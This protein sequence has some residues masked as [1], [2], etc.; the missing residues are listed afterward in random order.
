MTFQDTQYLAE[1]VF[2][3]DDYIVFQSTGYEIPLDRCQSPS[4]I[5]AWTHHLTEKARITSEH[6][7]R[8]IQLAGMRIGLSLH[9]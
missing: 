6:L 4:E 1:E 7:R 8:F 9:G 3:E 2:V 5:L